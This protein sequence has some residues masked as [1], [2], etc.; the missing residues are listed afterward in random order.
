MGSVEMRA[1]KE[2]RR[3]RAAALAVAVALA[4]TAAVAGCGDGKLDPSF[5]GDGR[6]T[7]DVGSDWTELPRDLTIDPQGRIVITGSLFRSGVPNAD[8]FVARLLQDGSPDPQFN[9]GAAEIVDGA[10]SSVAIDA[11]GRIVVAGDGVARLLP[12]GAPDPSF[13]GDGKA[14]LDYGSGMSGAAAVTIDD[15]AR[16]VVAGSSNVS[17]PPPFTEFASARLLANGSPDPTFAGGGIANPHVPWDVA[18]ASAIVVDGDGRIVLAGT[19]TDQSTSS[20]WEALRLLP[21]GSIDDSFGDAGLVGF[22][23]TGRSDAL[24]DMALDPQ[25]RIV[26]AGQ[27]SPHGSS[28]SRVAVARLLPSGELDPGFG[29][30]ARVA[31]LG[32]GNG[33]EAV[34]ID[35]AGRIVVAGF[36]LWPS[37][38]PLP[39]LL[40]SALLARFTG[41]GAIDRTFGAGGLI[42]LDYRSLSA[43]GGDN[44]SSLGIDDSGRYVIAGSSQRGALDGLNDQMGVARFT[45]DNPVNE[46]GDG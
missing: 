46:S 35:P 26:L 24:G 28:E 6:V 9:G 8:G 2:P 36:S 15:H 27:L 33:G 23:S 3:R 44:A 17:T 22:P 38:A 12:G 34:A 32:I 1:L 10:G 4:L 13:S 41:S 29:Q 40:A 39:E 43:T 18:H 31:A 19:V 45:I 25:G 16:I 7:L 14:T 37:G 42:R 11:D 30:G 20:A 21:G 5:G